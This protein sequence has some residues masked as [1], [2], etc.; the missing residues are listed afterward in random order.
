MAVDTGGGAPSSGM[1]GYTIGGGG[2]TAPVGVDAGG[3]VTPDQVGY[4]AN[5]P[6]WSL[7]RCKRAYSDYLAAKRLEIIEQQ[8]ARRY[9]HGAHWTREQ[10]A[11]FNKRKQP[12]VT[13]NRL[14]RKIDGIVGLTEKLRTEPK[15]FANKPQYMAGADLATAALNSVLDRQQWKAKSPMAAES[16]AID[17]IGGVELILDQDKYGTTVSFEPVQI[18]GF[19]YDPRSFRPDFSDA[20]YMGMG[21]WVDLEVAR[22]AL[23]GVQN[24]LNASISQ[25]WGLTSNSD[26]DKHWFMMTSGELKSVRLVYIC[27]QQNGTWCWALFTGNALL[28]Q[29]PSHFLNKDGKSICHFQMFS[30]AVDHDGDRYGFARNL[31]SAQDEVN[32]RR[33]K[34]LHELQTRRIIAEKGAFDDIEK[35]RQEA[36]RPD[37]VVERN[38][39]YD[40]EFDDARKQQDVAGQLKFLEDA[41]SEIE[42]FGPNPALL[43]DQGIAN[44]SGRAVALMQQAGIAELGPYML[45]W[46]N[47]KQRVSEAIFCAIQRYWTNQRWIRV[48]DQEGAQ[49]LVAV[50]QLQVDQMGMPVLVNA[51]GEL[52]VDIVLDEGPDTVTMMEDMY[53]TLS[54]IVPAIAPMLTPQEV[55]AVIQLLIETSPLTAQ[56]KQRFKA[57]AQ[58][59]QQPD[60]AQQMQ[61]KLQL[62]HLAAKTQQSR[63]QAAYNMARAAHAGAPSGQAAAQP[64]KFQ[65]PPGIAIG[66][67][68][69]RTNKDNADAFHK[70]ALGVAE[71]R[72]T[73][74]QPFD[75]AQRALAAA[76]KHSVDLG[77]LA[78]RHTQSQRDHH[79]DL[80]DLA[81]Q[82]QTL[83]QP[84]PNGGA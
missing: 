47:W 8:E 32:Q 76:R 56:A 17:G 7:A 73:Q 67:A 22:D 15:A 24:E 64:P 78:L 51:L 72:A 53:E 71:H 13:Y 65:L 19:F 74:I 79:V 40:A 58:Q 57:A 1:S 10:V 66:Q 25:A 77:D 21:K 12:V 6:Y 45:N 18:E 48:T 28:M 61:Q 35:A 59:A 68:M 42:N 31:R 81:L 62:E 23:P 37:G 55:Q 46:K 14:G 36:V 30:A 3:S 34:G 50:N 39:G 49:Q 63:S 33:S 9:R 82:Q 41:R 60:P 80:A 84:Q 2:A 44:R 4:V 11:I 29:G 54:Q 43:G 38:K 20:R 26:Y 52:D 75:Y 70:R 5:Q 83:N 16:A 27:Y 69:A